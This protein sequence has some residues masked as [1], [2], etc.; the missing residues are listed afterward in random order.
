VVAKVGK[1]LAVSKQAAR[2]IDVEIFN[3]KKL[4]NMEV[5]KHCNI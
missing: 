5:R 2:E 4:C 3:L 1:R